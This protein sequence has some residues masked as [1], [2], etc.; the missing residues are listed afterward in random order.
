MF[1]TVCII[2]SHVYGQESGAGDGLGLHR[3][4]SVVTLKFPFSRIFLRVNILQ[5]GHFEYFRVLICE[6]SPG[7]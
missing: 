6:D 2:Q 5:I 7:K 4:I 3:L 1:L